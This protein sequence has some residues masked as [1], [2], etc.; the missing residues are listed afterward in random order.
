MASEFVS[1]SKIEMASELEGGVPKLPTSLDPPLQFRSP[2]W[3]RI[4]PWF[5]NL[6]ERCPGKICWHHYEICEKVDDMRSLRR[7]SQPQTAEEE[8]EEESKIM[9]MKTTEYEDRNVKIAAFMKEKQEADKKRKY[10]KQR[11]S[12]RLKN[13]QWKSEEEEEV[14]V[15]PFDFKLTEYDR[16]KEWTFEEGKKY[17]ISEL[18]SGGRIT[19]SSRKYL[20]NNKGDK[21]NCLISYSSTHLIYV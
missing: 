1:F 8:E 5:R 13:Q 12:Q 19:R 3:F 9:K 2:P 17:E 10:T 18:L 15:N 11:C 20:I 6:Q 21:V 4:P 14:K 16:I 7:Q